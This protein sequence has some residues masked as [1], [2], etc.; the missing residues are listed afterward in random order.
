MQF[1]TQVY[2]T[3]RFI[4]QKGAEKL[5]KD[6]LSV[7]VTQKFYNFEFSAENITSDYGFLL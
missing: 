2:R 3:S 6:E 7:Q 4:H 1:Q 5:V